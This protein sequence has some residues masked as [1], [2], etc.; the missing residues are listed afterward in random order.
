MNEGIDSIKRILPTTPAGY[1]DHYVGPFNYDYVEG[2]DGEKAQAIQR[3]IRSVLDKIIHYKEVHQRLLNEA[4][5][6]LKLVLPQDITINNVLPFLELPP[7]T[8][9]AE[10]QE[11]EDD[12]E[13]YEVEVES[14]SEGEGPEEDS[15]GEG[16][17]EEEED[18]HEEVGN[19]GNV[20]QEEDHEEYD[21]D[22]TEQR[23]RGKRQRR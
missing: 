8:F 20:G 9:E 12:E 18:Y 6:T 17:E 1:L 7:N 19:D 21:E 2:D 15:D 3:W 22:G 23:G 13:D 11:M 16:G 14:S 10:D 4:A 5:A